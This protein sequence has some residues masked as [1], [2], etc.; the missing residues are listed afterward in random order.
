[1][2]AASKN[3]SRLAAGHVVLPSYIASNAGTLIGKINQG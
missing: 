2:S 3:R 1:M